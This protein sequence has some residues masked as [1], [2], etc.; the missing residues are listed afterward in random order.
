MVARRTAVNL[1]WLTVFAAACTER[2]SS[3]PRPVTASA[4]PPPAGLID[5]ATAP[6]PALAAPISTR[7][8]RPERA[9]DAGPSVEKTSTPCPGCFLAYPKRASRAD[10]TAPV[11]VPL[12]VVLHGDGQAA[13]TMYDAWKSAAAAR[14]VA[15]LAIACPASEGCKGSFWRWNGDPAW[16]AQQVERTGDIV[17][18]DDSRRWLLGF[19]GGA[20]YIGWR[21]QDLERDFGAVVIHAGGMGP[22]AD[23]C[24]SQKR[25]VYFLVGDKNPF[26]NLAQGLRAHYTKCGN[27]VTWR[28]LEGAD[29]PAE[30]AA[31]TQN[32]GRERSA[33]LDWLDRQ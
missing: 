27:A 8:A 15:V 4:T 33:V 10:A 21:A 1:I 6:S 2:P 11:S 19:S 30:W 31:L 17:A 23:E 22:A 18:L 26:H 13:K 5:A 28:L 16:L 20:S 24:T 12:L 25:P 9:H 32:G 14:D 7:L 3:P 29:H